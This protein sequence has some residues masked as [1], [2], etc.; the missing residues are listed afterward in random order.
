MLY[1]PGDTAVDVVT[2][3]VAAVSAMP[4][5]QVPTLATEAFRDFPSVAGAPFTVSL[6]ATL[7]IGRDAMPASAVPL[8][9][10]AFMD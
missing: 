4:V 1:I 10:T 8:S 2:E 9:G 5:G 3:P 7:A 6:A